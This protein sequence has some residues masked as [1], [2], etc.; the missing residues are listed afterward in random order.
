MTLRL[1]LA[2]FLGSLVGVERVHKRYAAGIRTF[3]LV[4]LGSALATV[5]G[6]YLA[7]MNPAADIGRI[8]AGIVS[9]VSFLGA[10]IILVTDRKQIKGLTTAADLWVTSTLGIAIGAG[11]L[12]AGICCVA[13][14]LL[15]TWLMSHISTYVEEHTRF[16]ELYVEVSRESVLDMLN[17]VREQGYSVQTVE[18]RSELPIIDGDITLRMRLDMHTRS[19]HQSKVQEISHLA[20]VHYLEE[21]G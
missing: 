7:D 11:F 20:G 15:T 14:I 1:V 12:W 16:I 17:Y 21:I 8:P 13:L 3:A 19:N 10:G 18:R 5:M 2:T 4:S 9:G 6:L